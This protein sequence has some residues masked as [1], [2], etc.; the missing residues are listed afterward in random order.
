MCTIYVSMQH[1]LYPIQHSYW[2]IWCALLDVRLDTF[3]NTYIEDV[4]LDW[5]IYNK[6]ITLN[7]HAVH[8]L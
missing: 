5:S 4:M 1:T 6:C 7:L 2:Y 8:S 3:Q